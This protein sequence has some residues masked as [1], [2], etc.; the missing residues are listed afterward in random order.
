MLTETRSVGIGG[1]IEMRATGPI[2][3]SDTTVSANV[4]DVRPKSQI[5]PGRSRQ[6]CYIGR[7]SLDAGRS[8]LRPFQRDSCRRRYCYQCGS[9]NLLRPRF[10]FSA[11]NIGIGQAGNITINAGSQFL[12]QNASV[13]T[14]AAR[15]AAAIFSSRPPIRSGS[16]TAQL[17]TSVQGGPD[18]SGGNITLDPAFMTLQNSQVLAQAVQGQGGNINIIAGTF[19]ADPT[20]V[21]SASSQF[22]LSGAVNIQS[23]LSR[24]S[25]TLA[26]LPQR[27]LQVHT[28]CNNAVPPRRMVN[29]AASWWRDAIAPVRARRMADESHGVAFR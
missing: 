25:N 18:T 28:S 20:S 1:K 29:S 17:S 3:L 2:E 27:P 19:L 16:L 8:D 24:L 21:V 23:P 11:S 9:V 22:G 10:D 7:K 26:T 5:L 13:T 14:E 12:S 15:R 4:N 6:H